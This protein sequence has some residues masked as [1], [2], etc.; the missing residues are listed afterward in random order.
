MKTFLILTLVVLVSIACNKTTYPIRPEPADTIA[1]V[2][3]AGAEADS[4]AVLTERVE[5]LEK[6]KSNPVGKIFLSAV[7]AVTVIFIL[8]PAISSGGN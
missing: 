3:S 2:D 7:A 6:K 4:L 5:K 1:Q 8:L